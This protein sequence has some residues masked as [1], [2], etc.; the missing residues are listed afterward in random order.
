[1]APR[2]VGLP[3]VVHDDIGRDNIDL[4]IRCLTA[5]SWATAVSGAAF[6]LLPSQVYA[7]FGVMIYGTGGFP[8]AY[9]AEEAAYIQLA[10]NVMGALMAGWFSFIA[11]YVRNILPRRIPGAWR[12]LALALLL[13]FSLDTTYSALAGF[14]PNAVLNAGI[15]AA[16]APGFWLTRSLRA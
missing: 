3:G 16:F 1:M 9:G 6:V 10:H 12:S 4:G 15:L 7:V 2:T 5:V 8:A 13:W 11:W 14:W